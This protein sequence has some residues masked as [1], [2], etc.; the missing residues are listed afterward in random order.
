MSVPESNANLQRRYW[1]GPLLPWVPEM[2]EAN[3]DLYLWLPQSWPAGD[4]D[5][6]GAVVNLGRLFGDYQPAY[7]VYPE[8]HPW[9][10]WDGN[11]GEGKPAGSRDVYQQTR[12]RP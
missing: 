3:L 10:G 1:T 6:N 11:A 4:P 7:D 2:E 5:A 9:A 8:P 12:C